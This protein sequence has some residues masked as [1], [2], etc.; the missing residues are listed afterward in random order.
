MNRFINLYLS[1]SFNRFPLTPV[2]KP[3]GHWGFR[4]RYRTAGLI[5]HIALTA[6]GFVVGSA[7]VEGEGGEAESVGDFDGVGL[8]EGGHEVFIRW[9]FDCQVKEHVTFGKSASLG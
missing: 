3:D 7:L 2:S 1:I 4:Y 9:E 8:G 5:H 6:A